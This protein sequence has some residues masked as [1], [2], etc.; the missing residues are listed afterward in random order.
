MQNTLLNKNIKDNM[1]VIRKMACKYATLYHQ[2]FDDMLS[3]CLFG[4]Y[5]AFISYNG[6]GNIKSHACRYMA[7]E[8]MHFMRDNKLI[9]CR[10]NEYKHMFNNNDIMSLDMPCDDETNG[11]MID[12]LVSEKSINENNIDVQ[13]A[14]SI[15]DNQEYDIIEKLYL[16]GYKQSE[17][18]KLYNIYE[19][20]IDRIHKKAIDKMRNYLQV[21]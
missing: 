6:M 1:Q 21:V 4:C 17:I 12:T 9:K 7:S 3:C 5:K 18:A 20:K 10:N 14:M 19:M 8:M 2:N 15:L 11:C 13:K 16:Q